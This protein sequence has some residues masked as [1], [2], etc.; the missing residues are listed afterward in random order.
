MPSGASL[1]FND[2]YQYQER[3]RPADVHIIPRTRGD[4][5]A[6]LSHMTLHQLTLQQGWQ[7]LPAMARTTLHKS[8][9]SIIFHSGT[10]PSSIKVD[11]IDLI[12]DGLVL[13]APAEEH[14]IQTSSVLGE[15][16]VDS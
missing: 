7:S 14:F 4:F 6:T 13:A 12:P 5:R 10:E 9:S 8:R 3:I 15:S 1:S 11:G 16:D 2:P